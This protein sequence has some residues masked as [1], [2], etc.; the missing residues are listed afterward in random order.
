MANAAIVAV[1]EQLKLSL[2]PESSD[3]RMVCVEE[4]DTG[5]GDI[6]LSF[7]MWFAFNK[8]DVPVCMVGLRET[9]GHYQNVGLKF[10]YN[11]L[12]MT[13]K[14]RF[15]FVEAVETSAASLVDC[16]RNLLE[17]H[18][19]G[20]VYMI[21][22]DISTLLLLGEKLENIVGFLTFAK[23]QQR[24]RLVF[25]CWKHKAD[26][27]AKRLAA[28]ASH[29]SDVRV[30]L[31]PLATG[32]SSAATGTMSITSNGTGHQ[33]D[34]VSYLYKLVDNGF[35]LTLNSAVDR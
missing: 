30:A 25:G 14:K 22:D 13:N 31:A 7:Y 2:K 33:T 34:S 9:C 35:T 11:L 12:V 4:T 24:L 32:F 10:Q 29:L 16:A 6:I 8:T 17:Q 28:A 5:K 20:P 27:A 3:R 15:T 23:R 19:T 26:E 1:L 18:P 21:V